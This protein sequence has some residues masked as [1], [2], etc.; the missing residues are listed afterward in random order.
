MA[1]PSGEQT[2]EATPRGTESLPGSTHRWTHRG[3]ERPL[4]DPFRKLECYS[5][6]QPHCDIHD[7]I[8]GPHI[9]S[10]QVQKL[11]TFRVFF[12][13]R[14]TVLENVVLWVETAIGALVF[15]SVWMLV[16][17]CS[18][19]GLDRFVGKEG[20]IRAFIAMFTTLVGPYT[21]SAL[22]L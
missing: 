4:L 3:E 6:S 22:W 5:F 16:Y 12:V 15:W 7:G 18:W 8:D 20:N 19:E 11:T 9:N 17:H 14:G 1:A 10:Y 13:L 2:P 21:F